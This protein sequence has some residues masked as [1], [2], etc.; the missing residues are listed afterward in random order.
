MPESRAAI[1]ARFQEALELFTAKVKQDSYIIAAIL[2]GSMSY[3]QVW[4]KSD[5]D[6]LLVG[7]SE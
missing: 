1:K 5:L 4:E 3:D 7:R 6:I 2:G